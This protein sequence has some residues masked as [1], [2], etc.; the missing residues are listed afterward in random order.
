MAFKIRKRVVLTILLTLFTLFITKN[1]W[2]EKKPIVT[3][4]EIKN[5]KDSTIEVLLNKNF[6]DEFIPCRTR[7]A[8]TKINNDN[9]H[10]VVV[11]IKTDKKASKVRLIISNLKE[12][13]TFELS[14]L[15]LHIGKC[16]LDKLDKFSLENGNLKIEKN[17]LI[18][19]PFA[20]TI[21]LNYNEP[22]NERAPIRFI[23]ETF[24]IILILTFL[25]G[26]K[27]MNYVAD[28][29][30]L[31]NKS[32]IDIVFL[33]LFFTMLFIPMLHINQENK[34]ITENRMLATWKSITNKD[35]SINYN[36]GKDYE[37]W[38]NDR[39]YLRKELIKISN[40]KLLYTAYNPKGIIDKKTGFL[41]NQGDQKTLSDIDLKNAFD[42]LAKFD[43]FLT[44]NNIKF[45]LL[46]VP[47]KTS[48]YPTELKKIRSDNYDGIETQRKRTKINVIYPLKELQNNTSK[49]Y[50][51]FRTDHH[52]TDSG[53]YIGYQELLKT[54]KKD[55]PD[56]NI[57]TENDYV[58][59]YRKDVRA[60]EDRNK[61][62]NGHTCNLFSLSKEDCNKFLKNNYK[63][64]KYK[65]SSKIKITKPDTARPFFT[66]YYNSSENNLKAILIGTSM[67]E[68]I[69]E[70]IQHSFKYTKKIRLNGV[71]NLKSGEIF[72][73][74]KYYKNTI[75]DTKP[76]ILI[77]C[78]TID[79][80]TKIH[81][82]FED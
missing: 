16:K 12:N 69:S 56:I 23:I 9:N 54:I 60:E 70:F 52:W 59:F 6:D 47:T 64:Y 38:F 24:T 15:R 61:F 27:L 39:F 35:G 73:I 72:K 1:T 2:L 81:K 10:N 65:Y 3:E 58:Y 68:N 37:A 25:L 19:T 32:R 26:Y 82:I 51:Y 45:Y 63:Y 67:I 8:K 40:K 28:F 18:I 36:F 20:N 14:N 7:Q 42:K 17:V 79:N 50:M 57:V 46:I 11:K 41:Y 53:A 43:E 66:D 76:D 30:S 31:K 13:K 5:A 78:I 55:Y 21:E 4:F 74:M 44:K 22:I 80:L 62:T 33:S 29:S 75:L 71:K 34:S 49:E 48:I 77:L